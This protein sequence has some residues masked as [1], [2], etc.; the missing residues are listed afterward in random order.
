MASFADAQNEVIRLL[1]DA[2]GMT[3]GHEIIFDLADSNGLKDLIQNSLIKDKL[4]TRPD[5]LLKKPL[6]TLYMYDSSVVIINVDADSVKIDWYDSLEASLRGDILPETDDASDESAIADDESAIADDESAIADDESVHPPIP[7]G[8]I[9]PRRTKEAENY[10]PFMVCKAVIRKLYMHE[11][12]NV[13]FR[14]YYSVLDFLAIKYNMCI[15]RL[16]K[17]N[18]IDLIPFNTIQGILSRHRC[19][20]LWGRKLYEDRYREAPKLSTPFP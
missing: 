13:N 6:T 19:E 16:I 5:L 2:S 4:M 20:Y 3:V 7:E 1:N 11:A 9:A 14:S 17:T 15:D 18:P 10:W 12:T 8:A